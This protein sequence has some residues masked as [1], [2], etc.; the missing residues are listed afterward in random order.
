M[1]IF[2]TIFDDI[3]NIHRSPDIVYII[4]TSGTTGDPKPVFVSHASVLPNILD[5]K[6]E[7]NLLGSDLVLLS[8]PLT[9][10]P[11]MVDVFVTLVSGAALLVLP[12]TEKKM[13]RQLFQ[14][15]F[16]DNSVSVLQCTPS[17]VSNIFN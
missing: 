5:F 9:F 15:L 16:V 6:A 11:S 2:L 17:L 13:R 12:S 3:E 10:D 1:D 14:S 7:F 8:S 4:Q